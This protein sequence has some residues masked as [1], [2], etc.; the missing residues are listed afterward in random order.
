[1]LDVAW[2]LIKVGVGLVIGSYL[3]LGPMIQDLL[4]NAGIA[5]FFDAAFK[6][7]LAILGV[8]CAIVYSIEVGSW[9]SKKMVAF[10]RLYRK[11]Q[12][13]AAKARIR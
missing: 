3:I 1:M 8:G 5:P 13:A 4:P 10:R 7:G 9:A 6:Y 11:R 2:R 12:L